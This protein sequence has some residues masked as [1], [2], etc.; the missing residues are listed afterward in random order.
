MDTTYQTA[1]FKD[2]GG[3]RQNFA[4]AASVK[5]IDEEFTASEYRNILRGTKA[6]VITRSDGSVALSSLGGSAPCVIPSEYGLIIISCDTSM[7][8]ISARMYSA[9]AGERVRI[10][11]RAPSGLSTTVLTLMFSGN[12]DGIAGAGLIGTIVKDISSIL[13]NASAASMGMVELVA[14]A[15]GTWAVVAT[16]SVTERAAS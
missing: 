8:T 10:L 5:I 14:T 12:A 6:V 4:S 9:V 2:K 3:D 11:M 16:R 7:A 13:L 1:I 15:N